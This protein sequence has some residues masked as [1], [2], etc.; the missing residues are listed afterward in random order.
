[1]EETAI[2][3]NTAAKNLFKRERSIVIIWSL[4]LILTFLSLVSM[5]VTGFYRL[6]EVEATSEIYGDYLASYKLFISDWNYNNGTWNVTAGQNFDYAFSTTLW[7]QSSG[8]QHAV[9]VSQSMWGIALLI[10]LFPIVRATISCFSGDLQKI[11]NYWAYFLL[12][13]F[14]QLILLIV[15][16]TEWK[17][18]PL[19]LYY[20]FPSNYST[21][22][23]FVDDDEYDDDLWLD[24][25]VLI[26][27]D[28]VKYPQNSK[29]ATYASIQQIDYT[30]GVVFSFLIA[31]CILIIVLKI[32]GDRVMKGIT[33][34]RTISHSIL[35]YSL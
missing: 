24:D 10:S 6:V 5:L 12:I 27:G 19:P 11:Y 22:D 20:V 8:A 13:Y 16:Y 15:F 26:I 7:A 35:D 34:I 31:L 9:S 33:T 17:E 4:W 23:Y 32:Q 1:M 29:K 18:I 14:L 2:L 25:E 21:I 28:W 30:F 3:N